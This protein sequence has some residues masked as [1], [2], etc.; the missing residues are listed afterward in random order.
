LKLRF[1]VASQSERAAPTVVLIEDE[2]ALATTMCDAL[3]SSG[4]RVRVAE[5]G[6]EARTL[7]NEA[8]PDLIVLD[9]MLPDVDGLVLCSAL[10]AIADTPIVICSASASKRDAILGLKLGADDFIAKPFDIYELEAR[11][12]AVLRRA[13]RSS[14]PEP[15]LPPEDTIRLGNLVIYSAKRQVSV[16]GQSVAL[17]PTE[18]RLLSVLASRPDLVVSRDDLASRVWG[19]ENASSGRTIDVHIRRL[20]IKLS[21]TRIPAPTIETVRGAGYK[22]ADGN[23]GLPG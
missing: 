13:R 14:A 5:T 11:L 19:Y 23:S 3:D 4:Y 17:T 2:H 21:G 12:E 22:L 10:K 18:Y 1:A 7:V 16:G 15:R 6:A 20:R 8:Q 9:L